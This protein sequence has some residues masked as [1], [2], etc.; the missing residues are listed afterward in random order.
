MIDLVVAS[1]AWREI[2]TMITA[3]PAAARVWAIA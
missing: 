1:P 2:S 3:M